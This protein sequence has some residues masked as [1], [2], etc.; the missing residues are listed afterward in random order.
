MC[1]NY[2]PSAREELEGK[3]VSPLPKNSVWPDETYKDYLAPIILPNDGNGRKSVLAAFSMVPKQHIPPGVKPLSTMNARSETVGQR[4]SYSGAWK[5]CQLCLVPMK[6]FYEPNWETGIHER[7]SIGMADD[8]DFAVA[9]I[10][11]EWSEQDGSISNAFTQLTVN[12]DDHPLMKKFHKQG[13]EK[14][15]LVII[16]PGEY[17]EWL[18]CKDP[19]QARSFL[20]LYPPELM[21][22]APAPKPKKLSQ[23]Y[24]NSNRQKPPRG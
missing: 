10:W 8:Q 18:H 6:C 19:E 4:R 1:T 15:S 3:F 12:A 5:K 13:E 14:R 11:R 16:P 24:W 17:D 9:G 20:T 22:A 21:A 23:V 2:R 7:W